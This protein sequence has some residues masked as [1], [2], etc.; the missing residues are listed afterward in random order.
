[1]RLCVSVTTSAT[2]AEQDPDNRHRQISDRQAWDAL[3][4]LEAI[5]WREAE[6][7]VREACGLAW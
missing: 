6:N 5:D 7:R 3:E 4:R 2:A 1:M